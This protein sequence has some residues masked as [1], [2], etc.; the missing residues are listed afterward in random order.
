VGRR[1]REKQGRMQ[2]PPNINDTGGGPGGKKGCEGGKRGE[3]RETD[4]TF[5]KK[6]E[7]VR[8]SRGGDA[9]KKTHKGGGGGHGKEGTN[10]FI[11][12][13]EKSQAY[14][15]PECAIQEGKTRKRKS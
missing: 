9:I 12:G 5:E 1:E 6:K 2:A 14:G 13:A 7:E 4:L 3:K 8:V 15:A 11:P 10:P